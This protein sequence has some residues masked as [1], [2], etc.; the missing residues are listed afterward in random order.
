MKKSCKRKHYDTSF[1]P[2]DYVLN[3]MRPV[4]ATGPIM[5]AR[6]KNHG[7]LLAAVQGR[8]TA[9]DADTLI[10]AFNRAEAIATLGVGTEYLAELRLANT[11]VTCM[12]L[13]G[14]PTGPEITAMNLGIEIHDAQLDDSRTTLAL[15]EQA[16]TAVKRDIRSKKQQRIREK[17]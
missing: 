17:A 5:T 13:R 2:L 15:L 12:Q 9:T 4:S 16:L 3:G 8:A 14:G 6:I 7:A 11:S 1:S 10:G